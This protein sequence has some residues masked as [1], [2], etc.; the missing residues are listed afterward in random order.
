MVTIK[1]VSDDDD[2]F[3]L[4]ELENELSGLV[5]D[6]ALS[7]IS[8]A[9]KRPVKLIISPAQS[10]LDAWLSQENSKTSEQIADEMAAAA[11]VRKSKPRPPAFPSTTLPTPAPFSF[12]T[13]L[14]A[15]ILSIS[16]VQAWA[17]NFRERL[18]KAGHF[19]KV[20][21]NNNPHFTVWLIM[22]LT[23]AKVV[24]SE[25]EKDALGNREMW[26][27]TFGQMIVN[28]MTLEMVGILEER[29][30][31]HFGIVAQ[32]KK[33]AQKEQTEFYEAKKNKVDSELENA[34]DPSWG[35][36]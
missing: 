28:H 15:S 14:T 32:E 11:G 6:S 3:D 20:P 34:A 25:K 29:V 35:S 33:N 24:L 21:G 2:E 16:D 12:S 27:G 23:E 8:N 31:Q 9:L 4:I 30:N 7:D 1:I 26:D 10:V 22:L 36:W 5:S 13:G 17:E 18:E 19:L